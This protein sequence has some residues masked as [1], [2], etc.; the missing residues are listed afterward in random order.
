MV[1]PRAGRHVASPW[2]RPDSIRINSAAAAACR[3][4]RENWDDKIDE[5]PPEDEEELI[6]QYFDQT[7]EEYA[8]T[9]TP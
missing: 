1:L 2:R 8:I 5:D 7:L 3:R 6:D 4:V 9:E